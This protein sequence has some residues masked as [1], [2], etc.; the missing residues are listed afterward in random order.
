MFPTPKILLSIALGLSA[1]PADGFTVHQQQSPATSLAL[2]G[3]NSWSSSHAAASSSCL[4]SG[5]TDEAFSPNNANLNKNGQTR[6]DFAT[7][8]T[9][10][11]I[12][13]GISS[14]PDFARAAGPTIQG[15]VAV[16]GANGKTGYECVKAL[17][18]RSVS[19]RACSRT[20]KFRGEASKSVEAR[21]CD[22]TNVSTIAPAVAGASA[23]IFAASAS[24]EG[25]TPAV[26]DNAGL[27]AVANACI[28]AKVKQLVIVSSGAVTK[29][30]SPVYLF[31]NVFGKIMEEKIKG[32]DTVRELYASGSPADKEGLSYTVVRPG[33]LTE[34]ESLG[35]VSDLEL[36]QG[37]SKSGRIARADVANICV[38]AL[39]NPELTGRTTFECYNADTGAPLA[40]VG[41]SNILKAKTEKANFVSGR[42][43]RGSSWK[44]MFGSLEKD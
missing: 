44:E 13:A 32:E 30:S 3:R 24:K 7:V 20:G 22:V 28:D 37:D 11:G 16:I 10:A 36:N 42:E 26:V 31:L 21:V 12:L 39:Y 33:G 18:S 27:V 38:E 35:S 15:P 9:S 1:V 43:C 4:F 19:V 8:A 41:I 17:Q 25:G 6:R 2:L 34:E 40:S 29:P 5:D 14:L 23:V